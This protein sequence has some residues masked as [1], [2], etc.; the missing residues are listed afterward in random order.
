MRPPSRVTAYVVTAPQQW[1]LAARSVRTPAGDTTPAVG[2]SRPYPAGVP[3]CAPIKSVPA[4][5]APYLLPPLLRAPRDAPRARD[6]ARRR[7]PCEVRRGWQG[8]T[9]LRPE[10]GRCERAAQRGGTA[11][12]LQPRGVGAGQGRH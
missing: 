12:P 2:S 1:K 7:V 9:C 10:E 6:L 8:R 11:R 4:P 5:R 3:S